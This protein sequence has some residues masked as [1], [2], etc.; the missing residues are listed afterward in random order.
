MIL[1]DFSE[2][3]EAGKWRVV[4]DGVM[5]GLSQSTFQIGD[6]GTAVFS[7]SVLL[8]NNGG[9][10]SVNYNTG[11]MITEGYSTLAIYLKGDGKKYQARIREKSSDYFSYIITFQTSGKWETIELPLKEMVP[12]FRGRNLDL[13]NFSGNNMVELTFLISNKTA[14]TF[15]LELQK[16]FLK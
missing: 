2:K 1:F 13:P 16:A 15:R 9:F 8:E 6:A 7:G 4:N 5:G 12:S 10:C 3:S 14:E 11:K